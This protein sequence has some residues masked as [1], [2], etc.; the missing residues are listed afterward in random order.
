MTVTAKKD[1][2][3]LFDRFKMSLYDQQNIPNYNNKNN[4]DEKKNDNSN[5]GGKI[6]IR[7]ELTAVNGKTMASELVFI[8]AFKHIQKEAKRFLKKKKIK[9]IKDNEIQWIITVP[10]I[11][12][13][14]AKNLMK[15]W[16]IKSGLVD[17][18]INNQ[19]KIVYE[20]DCAS[21]SILHHIMHKNKQPIYG[22][23]HN[24]DDN[25]LQQQEN[26]QMTG[27]EVGDKYILVDAGGGTVDIACHEII[28]NFEVKEIFHPSGGKWGSCYI[29]DQYIELLADIFGKKYLDE[30]KKESPN[31]YVEI[32]NDFQAA[33]AIFYQEKQES[34]HNVRLPEE[35]LS[36]VEDRMNDEDD[37]DDDIDIEDVVQN[38]QIMGQSKLNKLFFAV[39][40]I[41]FFLSE[42][43]IQF[44]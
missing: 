32:I 23:N 6:S 11:W 5:N 42:N 1:E 14:E 29:D 35:F 31:G 19:C 18:N 26:Q 13:D 36:F 8:A 21:L 15:Q 25:K 27:M 40:Y 16:A 20:P 24:N 4:H 38:Y 44:G 43:C 30:F 41:V 22:D 3:M 28:G 12:N 10:A 39:F 17:R 2:W 34:T 33:K 37:A 7:S 9:N